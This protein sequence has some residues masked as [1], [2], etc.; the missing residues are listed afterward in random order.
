MYN[1]VCLNM[2][3]YVHDNI[4]TNN[5]FLCFSYANTPFVNHIE[6]RRKR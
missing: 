4:Y 6:A 1:Y 2:I 3:S 5:G